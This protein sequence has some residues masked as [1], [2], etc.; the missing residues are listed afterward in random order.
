MAISVEQL[1]AHLD[2]A[3]TAIGTADYVAAEREALQA[4]ACLAGL[5]NGA[6]ENAASLEW[7]ET[8][9]QLLVN[10]RQAR[11]DQQ[12]AAVGGVQRQ[13]ITYVDPS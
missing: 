12:I 13:A 11:R 5:P 3:R 2:A 10:V 7:R 1:Q 4:Q 8:I 6:V 9:G